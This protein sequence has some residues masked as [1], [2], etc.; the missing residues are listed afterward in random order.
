MGQIMLYEPD[1]APGCIAEIVNCD[2]EDETVLIQT[3][4]DFPGVATTFGWVPC[5]K[6]RETDGTVDCAH[7]TASQMIAE[8]GEFISDHYG[9]T[10]DDPGYFNQE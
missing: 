10:V 3:D 4:W 5:D 9:D 2:N 7:K 1:N 6:C 8:A